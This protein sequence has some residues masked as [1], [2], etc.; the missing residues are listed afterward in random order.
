MQLR[1]PEPRT[2]LRGSSPIRPLGRRVLPLL[3]IIACCALAVPAA[4]A[5]ADRTAP[6]APTGLT[7][8]ALTQT[9]ATIAW[10]AATDNVR[11]V[12]YDVRLDGVRIGST[13]SLAYTF[14][15]LACG[16]SHRATVT[17]RDAAGNTRTSQALNF[18]TTACAPAADSTPPSAPGG[19]A[20]SSVTRTGATLN[21]T[22]STDNVGVASY[23]VNLNGSWFGWATATS[24][25]VSNLSCGT[26]YSVY[27]IALDAAGNYAAGQPQE[28]TTLSC[29]DPTPTDPVGPSGVAVPAIDLPGWRLIFA[30][31][32]NKDAPLG[33]FA[34]DCDPDK[35]VYTGAT[36]TQW[37]AYPKCYL[38]TYQKRPYRSDQVLSVSNG[39]LDFWLHNVD[40]QPAGANPSPVLPGGSQYQTYGRYSA[41]M[42][43][44]A[45]DLSE[46]YLAWLLWPQDESRWES[47]ESD[48]PEGPLVPGRNGVQGFSHY[49]PGSQEA[50]GDGSVDLH[51]WHTY[52]QEWTPTA[53]RYWVDDRLIHTTSHPV[54]AGPQRWQLQTETKGYGNNS[55]HLLVDWVA[56]YGYA[57]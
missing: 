28:L 6:S 24:Y 37:R 27:V 8:S 38:D 52:T 9:G 21:W 20:I 47:A 54:Y 25:T 29:T 10:K 51:E 33:S 31:D 40:G 44:E 42:K 12:A 11:V 53:R 34:S 13:R 57:P 7:A 1:T 36:G 35:I 3:S 43:V 46:Y 19:L 15:G 4:A 17:A 16:T 55:G 32:F 26:T 56:V 18:T 2:S 41:R 5:R 30:D 50:F 48:F 39:S 45:T 49:A 23:D 14:T 22:A